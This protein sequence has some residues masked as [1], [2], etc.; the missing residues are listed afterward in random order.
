MKASVELAHEYVKLGRLR[1][2]STIYQQALSTVQAGGVS[3]EVRIIALL[4]AA[5]SLA[6]TD[7]I[8]ARSVL[9]DTKTTPHLRIA[10]ALPGMAKL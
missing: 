7:D 3:E 2:A 6:M 10:S 8:A 1:T 5:E 4:R 9:L